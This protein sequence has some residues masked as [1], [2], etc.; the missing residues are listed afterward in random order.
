MK[1]KIRD[2]IPLEKIIEYYAMEEGLVKTK[3]ELLSEFSDLLTLMKFG[4]DN[5]SY[6]LKVF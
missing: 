1:K 5:V 3:D 4:E 2:P 6:H